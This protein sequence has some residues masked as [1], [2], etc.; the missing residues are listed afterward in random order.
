MRHRLLRGVLLF[1]GGI[2]L[3]V[4]ILPALAAFGLLPGL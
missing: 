1:L 2:V 4:M 3:A